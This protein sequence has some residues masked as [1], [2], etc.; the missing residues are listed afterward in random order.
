MEA[1]EQNRLP[2]S[3]LLAQM[4][5]VPVT[6][7]SFSSRFIAYAQ[8]ATLQNTYVCSHGYDR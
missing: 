3:E 5:Y 2:D 7:H 8:W 4:S 6:T 1:A